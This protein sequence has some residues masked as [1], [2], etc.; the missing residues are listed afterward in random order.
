ML[1]ADVL[2]RAKRGV[3]VVN[4]ARGPLIDEAALI[5][6]LG[7]GQVQ[8]AAL[9]VYEAEP[10]PAGSPL[11]GFDQCVFGSH[12]GSNTMDAV[13]RTSE[14]AIGLLAGFLGLK[15]AL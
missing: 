7:S 8:G 6:A 10:L 3:R 5:A 13:R 9:D 1:N 11:R 14:R 15:T 12:N 2:A 4:V